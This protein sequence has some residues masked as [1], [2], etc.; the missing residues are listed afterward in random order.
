MS[1]GSLGGS[2]G[3]QEPVLQNSLSV[4]R[5]PQGPDKISHGSLSH[6]KGACDGLTQNESGLALAFQGGATAWLNASRGSFLGPAAA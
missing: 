3:P 1:Q 6:S 5:G 4:F 2:R